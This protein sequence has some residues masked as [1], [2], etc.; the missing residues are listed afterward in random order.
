MNSSLLINN[1]GYIVDIIFTI[2][3]AIF[4]LVK[5]PQRKQGWIF[6]W[7]SMSILSFEV[8]HLIGT[9]V[10]D[11]E[12]SRMILMF[13]LG[14]IF[15]VCFNAHFIYLITNTLEKNKV[16]LYIGYGAGILMT[17]FFLV[18]PDTFLLTS[19]PKL[20]FPNYYDAG[21]LYWVM[22]LF[23]VLLPIHFTYVLIKAFTSTKDIIERRRY[24]YVGWGMVLG[25]VLGQLPVPL[26]FSIPVDPILSFLFVPIYV[27]PIGY[28]A[29]RYELADIRV[30]AQRAFLYALGVAGLTGLIGIANYA[31]SFIIRE[32]GSWGTWVLP[33][34]SS[35]VAIGIGTSVWNRTRETDVLKN[36]FISIISHKFRTPLTHIRWST[37][38]LMNTVTDPEVL[39]QIR[40]INESNKRLI[41][42]SNSLVDTAEGSNATFEYSLNPISIKELTEDVLKNHGAQIRDK[43]LSI[44]R[45]FEPKKIYIKADKERIKFAIQTLIENAIH[46]TPEEGIITIRIH[47]AKKK[48]TM[49]VEDTGIGIDER[50]MSRVF[51]RFYRTDAAR[52]QHTEGIGI[53]LYLTKIIAERHG[54][55][56]TAQSQGIGKGSVFTITL[57]ATQEA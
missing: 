4:I 52:S 56:I 48:V 5:S 54:G 47:E 28:A 33:A 25:Y 39:E 51:T 41:S 13:N 36:E 57:P 3:F 31:N 46:Y 20:Y 2:T 8:S 11:P 40:N 30:V 35:I 38:L 22:R 26:V 44:M 14:C 27:I 29:V 9:N 42:L 12:L 17:I 53:G 1:I 7:L 34:L 23:F 50:Q 43:H 55:K 6:F 10:A 37:E 24:R 45:E 19:K 49:Q 32:G 21:S 18:F 16:A 15:I